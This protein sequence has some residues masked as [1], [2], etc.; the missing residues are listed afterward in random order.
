M[1]KDKRWLDDDAKVRA[2]LRAQLAVEATWNREKGRRLFVCL[3]RRRCPHRGKPDRGCELC[4]IYP[5]QNGAD[6]LDTFVRIR[7]IGN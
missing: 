1:A 3:G 6:F 2:R 5:I 4:M 7:R